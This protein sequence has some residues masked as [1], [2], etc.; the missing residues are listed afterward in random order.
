[1]APNNRLFLAA[2]A[3]GLLGL[4]AACSSA[5][6]K[7]DEAPSHSPP[8]GVEPKMPEGPEVLRSGATAP[9]K[10]DTNAPAGEAGEAEEAEEERP[11]VTRAQVDAFIERGPSYAL[12]QVEVE[13]AREGGGFQGF[14]LVSAQR[15]ARNFLMPQLRVGDVITHI[16]GIRQQKPDDY[17]QA[18]KTLAN[19]S[20]IRIDFLRQSEPMNAIWKVE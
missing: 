11:S 12:T 14:Q 2:L 10:A 19:V 17:L 8:E 7:A 15:E 9:A 6:Q 13:P 3:V 20:T 18:W 5:P 1:M 4:G 16:N